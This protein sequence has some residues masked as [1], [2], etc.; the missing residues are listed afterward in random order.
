MVA[1]IN[2]WV[3]LISM[4]GVLGSVMLVLIAIL[5]VSSRSQYES[6]YNEIWKRY[7]IFVAVLWGLVLLTGFYNLHLVSGT[8]TPEYQAKLGMKMAFA[9]FMFLLTVLS[10]HPIPA[11]KRYTHN[12][13]PWLF[14]I[15]ILGLV[16]VGISAEL[17]ISRVNGTGIN[18]NDI[19]K[20]ILPS[21]AH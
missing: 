6:A 3:H 7:G 15:L 2:K 21:N 12:R 19:I 10:G 16:I 13:K 18:H 4:I 9:I 8:V 1:L 11:L 14:L 17:N 20:P 5:P